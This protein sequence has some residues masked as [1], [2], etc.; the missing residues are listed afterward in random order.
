MSKNK[1][2]IQGGKYHLLD[3]QESVNNLVDQFHKKIPVDNDE[4]L[5]DLWNTTI[6]CCEQYI[7]DNR[8][9]KQDKTRTTQ[10]LGNKNYKMNCDME[11]LEKKGFI[12]SSYCHDLA[13][14][15]ISKNGQ[16]QVFFIDID[17]KNMKIEGQDK[18]FV[19]NRIKTNS[20]EEV[21]EHILSTNDYNE[22]LKTVESYN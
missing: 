3:L 19:I 2:M 16:F 8:E 5:Q 17:D 18:K 13:P 6:K 7:K 9:E 22:M 14:S 12:C 11:E 10:W 1:T 21:L 4:D 20:N 15:Y